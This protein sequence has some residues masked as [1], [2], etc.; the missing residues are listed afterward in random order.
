MNIILPDN[1]FARI[2]SSCIPDRT[3]KQISFIPSSQITQK[4]I[5]ED[6]AIGLIPVMDLLNHKDLF[7]SS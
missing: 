7:V 2:I 1:I 3:A 5:N 4:I 6:S